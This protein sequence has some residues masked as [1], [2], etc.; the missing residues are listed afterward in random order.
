MSSRESRKIVLS[1]PP[2]APRCF[3]SW[4]ARRTPEPP[5]AKGGAPRGARLACGR[6]VAPLFRQSDHD[7]LLRALDH[8]ARGCALKDSACAEILQAVRTV[9]AGVRWIPPEILERQEERPV[10]ALTPREQQVLRLIADGRSN[11]E[12]ADLL[13]ISADTVK[14][15]SRTPGPSWARPIGWPRWPSR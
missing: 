3:V 1:R 7:D 4:P 6:R 10:A 15:T 2:L 14:R 13:G 5:L 11:Q 9:H 12:A 8:G